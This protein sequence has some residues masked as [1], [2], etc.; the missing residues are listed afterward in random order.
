MRLKKVLALLLNTSM[1]FAS[2]T[3]IAFAE[4]NTNEENAVVYS[5][6]Q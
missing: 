1:V 3:N 6:K 4:D 2:V 5:L